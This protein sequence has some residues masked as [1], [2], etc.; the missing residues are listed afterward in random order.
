MIKLIPVSFFIFVL[1]T[2]TV[3]TS[4]VFADVISP[5][6]Q[7]DLNFTA[8]E[9]ICKENLVKILRVSNGDAICV[10]F[11]IVDFLVERGFAVEPVSNIPSENNVNSSKP[12]GTLTHMATTKQF[13]NP[14]QVETFPKI[15]TFNYVFKVCAIDEKIKSPEI[16]ITSD[17]ETKSVKLRDVQTTS[18]YTTAALVKATDPDSISARLLN[19]GGITDAITE[20][21]NKIATLK[22][23]ITVQREKLLSIN[24]ESPSTDR[25]KKV[26]AIH[27]KIS[28]VRTELKSVKYE[29]QKYL[30]F[31]NLNSSSHISPVVKGKSITG[32]SIENVVSEIVSVNEALIQPE[33]RPENSMAY[34]VVFEI[35]TSDTPLRIPIVEL[36]SDVSQKTIMMAEKIVSNSCQVSTGKIIAINSN[37]ISISLVGQTQSSDNV[38]KL[39]NKINLLKDEM[40]IEQDKLNVAL[41]SSS[42]TKE[43]RENVIS[44]STLKIHELRKDLLT[45]KTELHKIL[46]QVYS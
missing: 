23:E 37:S 1:L 19:H 34:N 32:M 40:K 20:L 45:T 8:K 26:S 22:S 46:L 17:A 28:D 25:A 31:L 33:D 38:V 36:I 35:C 41:T 18:C 15:N 29:L 3:T 4:N 21:E 14:G 6:D 39:E 44:E 9:V 11:G 27:Q 13:K 5:K 30:L 12:V 24:D 10:T 42:I 16:I 2:S 7:M 43:E